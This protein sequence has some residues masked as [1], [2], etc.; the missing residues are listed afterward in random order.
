MT[1][2]LPD[3]QP[4]E[5]PRS[6]V[7][8]MRED[9]HIHA[10]SPTVRRRLADPPTF[11]E[12]ISPHF[13]DFRA[14]DE[15]CAFTLAL[16]MREEA[17]RLRREG[18]PNGAVVY[19]RDG[20]SAVESLTWSLYVEGEREVHVTVDVAYRP[21][22]GLWGAILEMLFHRGHRTQAFRDTLWN[23]KQSVERDRA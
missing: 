18:A 16:P 6:G 17:V 23:L 11:D 5:R 7:M 14:D 12:W 1:S 20:T 3:H 2:H 13:R 8:Y 22:G 9:I 21:A 10:S 19:L 4:A 15:G